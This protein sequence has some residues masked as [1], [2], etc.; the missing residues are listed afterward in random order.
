VKDL[1][2]DLLTA[3]PSG[4]APVLARNR[5]AAHR[6]AMGGPA[7]TE[8]ALRRRH[9]EVFAVF[10]HPDGP[11]A[12]L[13]LDT[14]GPLDF[15][16]RT[17]ILPGLSLLPRIG[18]GVAVELGLARHLVPAFV[19]VDGSEG[20]LAQH[21][22][23]EWPRLVPDRA[24]PARLRLARLRTRPGPRS[25]VSLLVFAD[26]RA[27]PDLVLK[28]NRDPNYPD[29]VEREFAMFSAIHARVRGCGAAIPQ[30]VFLERVG[31]HVV[32]G[33]T[34]LPG[35]PFP[36]RAFQCSERVRRRRVMPL[37]DRALEWLT[38]FHAETSTGGWALDADFIHAHGRAVFDAVVARY[39]EA[40]AWREEL[41]GIERQLAKFDGALLPRGA[42]HGDFTHANLLFDE[43]R[44][45]VVD[46]EDCEPDGLPLTDVFFLVCQLALSYHG[47]A[48]S[49]PA[50][51]RRFLGGDGPVQK[52]LVEGLRGYAARLGFDPRLIGLLLP[53]FLG[54][55]L[56]K[57]YPVH[58]ARTTYGFATL[59]CL[60]A[61]VDLGGKLA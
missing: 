13:P 39:P 32:F 1:D 3:V 57:E 45:A 31:R 18:V 30:P 46:W 53:S 4:G 44:V 40:V 16:Y 5:W 35:R 56:V 51:F 8:A 24:P 55:L 48:A 61:A 21:V 17:R 11:L 10:P 15:F 41:R 9:R 58:R 49:G 59:E 37:V 42:V 22:R 33:Q 12:V 23:R 25:T 19:A 52:R 50:S 43:R 6:A 27:A 7:T 28:V 29:S 26:D 36:V 14:P 60:R 38:A 47:E 20:A 34:A 54:G 2:L